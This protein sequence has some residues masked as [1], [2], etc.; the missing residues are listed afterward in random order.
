MGHAAE[1]RKYSEERTLSGG[2]L[3]TDVPPVFLASAQGVLAREESGMMGN[4]WEKCWE[5][6]YRAVEGTEYRCLSALTS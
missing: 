6:D 5:W 2:A 1:G 3:G 4:K